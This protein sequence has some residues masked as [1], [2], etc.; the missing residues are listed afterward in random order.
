[1]HSKKRTIDRKT[2]FVQNKENKLLK[3]KA[4][5]NHEGDSRLHDILNELRRKKS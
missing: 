1:M 5:G 2:D 3:K 4:V